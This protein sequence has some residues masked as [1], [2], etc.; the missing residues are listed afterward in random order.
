VQRRRCLAPSEFMVCPYQ[1]DATVTTNLEG[2]IYQ[3]VKSQALKV[4]APGTAGGSSDAPLSS[5]GNSNAN[6]LCHLKQSR[7][8]EI[9]VRGIR[10]SS[11]LIAHGQTRG[12]AP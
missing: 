11:V 1:T 12:N 9:A 8:V 2:T 4:L 3:S 7:A 5:G 10:D 6:R